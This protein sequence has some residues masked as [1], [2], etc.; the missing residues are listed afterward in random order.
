MNAIKTTHNL[1]FQ[2]APWARDPSGAIQLFKIGTCHGQWYT[3]GPAFVILSIV[4]DSPGNGHL[5]DVFQW[6]EYACKRDKYALVI[7]ELMNE[8][9]KKHC[10]EKRGFVEYK[11]NKLIQVK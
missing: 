11:P 10:I 5:D 3:H 2:V 9:F 1:D 4:N 8:R 6:F 7:D